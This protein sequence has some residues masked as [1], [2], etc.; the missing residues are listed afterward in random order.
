MSD[1]PI[2]ISQLKKE[3]KKQRLTY[4][5]VASQLG[6][7]EAS[8]KRLFA[9]QQFTLQRL[10][11]VCHMLGIGLAELLM[12][13]E[14]ER[15]K[16]NSLTLEQEQ[17][18]VSDIKLLLVT[19]LVLN[20]WTF[21]EILENYQ[22]S[23]PELIQLLVRLDRMRIIELLPE[24]RIRLI[25]AR[26][27]RWIKH[28]PIET[29]VMDRVKDAFLAARFDR[30]EEALKFVSGLLSR[31]SMLKIKHR[32]EKLE[33]EIHQLTE[34]DSRLPLTERHGF[35]ALLAIRFWEFNEFAAIRR[36]PS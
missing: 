2:L 5:D 31:H 10:E 28:G 21:K 30:S 12:E 8:V 6:L 7:S 29:F 26:D 24:N 19:Y 34:Q 11:Q 36:E 25:T 18:I 16:I 1:I 27:F 35:S 22:F 13:A 9:S 33:Q 4:Q 15:E 23:E 20:R 3:L 32:I 14:R 17:T